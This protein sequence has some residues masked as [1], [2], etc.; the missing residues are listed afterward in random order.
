MSLPG[1]TAEASIYKSTKSYWMGESLSSD[2]T[3]VPQQLIP[4]NPKIILPVGN[5][6]TSVTCSGTLCVC[7]GVAD[8]KSDRWTSACAP[9]TEQCGYLGCTCTW[10]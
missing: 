6:D 2:Y 10:K 4:P 1:F 3:I 5:S 8:C 9:N 7:A